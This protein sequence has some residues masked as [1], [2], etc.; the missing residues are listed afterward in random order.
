MSATPP[1]GAKSGAP[2]ASS[3]SCRRIAPYNAANSGPGS[4]PSSSAN[5]PRNSAYE[6]SASLCRPA[7]YR[8]RNC[9]ARSRSRSGY[10]ATRSA[11]SPVSNV[12]S[13]G[14]QP[15]LRLLLQ[16]GQPLLLKTVRRSPYERL[17]G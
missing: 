7:R 8:A 15:R 1:A 14:C 3:G 12:W 4:S 2:E 13:P 11:S 5:R 10:R 6:A 17:V 9:T 16:Y